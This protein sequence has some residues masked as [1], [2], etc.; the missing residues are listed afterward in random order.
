LDEARINPAAPQT[1]E[2]LKGLD[3]GRIQQLK[4]H[5]EKFQASTPNC[6]SKSLEASMKQEITTLKQNLPIPPP[7]PE[8]KAPPQKNEARLVAM[9]QAFLNEIAVLKAKLAESQTKIKEETYRSLE[10]R[11]VHREGE[12]ERQT[13][14]ERLQ[15][16]RNHAIQAKNLL[17]SEVAALR[18]KLSSLASSDVPDL[19]SDNSSVSS[20]MSKGDDVMGVPNNVMRLRSELA[21]ARERLA[22]A[23][24]NS[25]S[26]PIRPTTSPGPNYEPVKW[27]QRTTPLPD[28]ASERTVTNPS[29]TAVSTEGQPCVPRSFLPVAESTSN[30]GIDSVVPSKA[31]TTPRTSN[32]RSNNL[33][34]E[35]LTRQLEASRKRLQTADQR[36]NGLVSDGSLLT[37]VRKNPADATFDGSI[38]EVV[39]TEDGNIEVNHRRFAD[40]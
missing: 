30:K 39:D 36:L 4:A 6:D 40:V 3:D 21:Q 7:K 27:S 31:A 5:L 24:E 2:F 12:I 18:K 23:R 28:R 26:L 32:G 35:E 33:S 22:A 25:R 16:E 11:R 29:T 17:Q 9:E 1:Q 19:I 8:V 10:E 37:I 34:L 20:S 15:A 38:D 14:M 13:E